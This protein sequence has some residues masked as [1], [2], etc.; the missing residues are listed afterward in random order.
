MTRYYSEQL[1]EDV[2][3]T[4]Q[5]TVSHVKGKMDAWHTDRSK[6]AEDMVIG[7][8]LKP[9]DEV[10]MNWE[11]MVQ[12]F[13]DKSEKKDRG[14]AIDQLV[15]LVRERSEVITSYMNSMT[16]AD[17]RLTVENLA[18]MEQYGHK[19]SEL[20]TLT[21]SKEGTE[22]EKFAWV[23]GALRY[24]MG[25]PGEGQSTVSANEGKVHGDIAK[26]LE[27]PLGPKDTPEPNFSYGCTLLA[28][29]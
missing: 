11:G 17:M 27:N 24:V 18:K 25:L 6:F 29:A 20:L 23:E 10:L 1:P 22:K 14:E 4:I 2:K 19:F 13:T 12:E 26:A 15:K 28:F 16:P 7:H 3:N 9:L 5:D 8:L 21:T